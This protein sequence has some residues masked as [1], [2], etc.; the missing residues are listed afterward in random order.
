M[1]ALESGAG[2][3]S[4]GALEPTVLDD[5]HAPVVK[6]TSESFEREFGEIGSGAIYVWEVPVR[7][8]HWLIVAAIVVLTITGA[9]I[10]GPFLT[11]PTTPDA[12]D[13]MATVRF[14]H[15]LAAI[16]FMCSFAVRFYWGFAG[17]SFSSW[18][19]IIPHNRE[20]LYWG[21]E[22]AKYYLFM[23]RD[24]VP[25]TGHNFLAG[26]TYTIV[27]IGMV[28]QIVTG[29]L[30]MAWVLGIPL[31][32]TLFGWGGM[33]PGGIQ[34]VRMLH[35]LLTFMF[36]AFAIHHVYSAILVDYEERSGTMS[37]IFSGWKNIKPGRTLEA[38]GVAGRGAPEEY[39]RIEE[40]ARRNG[41][42]GGGNQGGGSHT[43]V[44]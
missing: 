42:H 12:A 15:E 37:S 17:N 21:R 11:P 22:M 3:L 1:A 10:H 8:T 25:V 19:A 5:S 35:F 27:S 20:Q 7:I 41:D 36:V 13:Q 23:R 28:A 18:R 39:R 14:I 38:L 2:T 16:I 26:A 4:T 40:E 34:T 29:L 31:I 32:T 6:L 24:P 43:A 30:L 9:Y 44:G 33:L